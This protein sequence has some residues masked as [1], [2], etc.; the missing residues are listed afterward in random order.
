MAHR[1]VQ[2]GHDAVVLTGLP[3][4]PSGVI[5]PEYRGKAWRLSFGELLDGIKVARVILYPSHSKDGNRRLA[6]YFSFAASGSLRSV[7]L[8]GVDVV[9]ATSP[10]L[11]AGLPA[12]LAATTNR[13]P[14]V[15]ELRDLWPEA[16]IQ[17]GYL[18]G[19]VARRAAYALERF[20]YRQ[21]TSIVSVSNGIRQDIVDRG[22]PADKCAVLFN[23][24]DPQ[25]FSPQARNNHVEALKAEGR[26]V[27]L[28]MG[29]LSAYHGLELALDLLSQLQPYDR[30]RVLFAGGGSARPALEEAV[31]HRGLS[32]AI[33]LPSPSRVE[34]PGLAA[35]ADF[36][37]AF[38]KQ[39]QF[40]RWLLSSK[41]FMYM[42][43]GRPIFAAAAGE[44][45]SVIEEARAGIV[46]E[47]TPDGVACLAQTLLQMP[48]G[49]RFAQFGANG[50]RYVEESHSWD[51][52]ATS[53]EQILLRAIAQQ[54]QRRD[55]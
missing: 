6:N 40:S 31:R 21:A 54:W 14:L 50:R 35:S 18:R 34:M 27:G 51:T 30:F 25:L 41:V 43:C 7:A 29:S 49:S 3:N 33:F 32:N 46:V 15:M 52:V 9:V 47:P 2:R 38:V 37:L 20:L 26:V 39:S 11:T 36:C 53:Y 24:I 42:A 4:Y 44:T 28:Y 1:L 17:L 45:R 5:A 12:W 10:P 16:A 55:V 8:R 23:G 22:V 19:P 13:A 48:D